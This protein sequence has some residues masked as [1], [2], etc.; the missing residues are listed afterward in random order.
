VRWA[1]VVVPL[2]FAAF[3]WR[4]PSD[5]TPDQTRYGRA[6]HVAVAF[7]CAIFSLRVVTAWRAQLQVLE[8]LFLLKGTIPRPGIGRLAQVSSSCN[9]KQQGS[10]HPPAVSSCRCLGRSPVYAGYHHARPKASYGDGGIA[11]DQKRRQGCA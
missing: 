2:A 1:A 10:V 5:L 7:I 3:Y 6:D 4:W 8:L 11:L 9:R